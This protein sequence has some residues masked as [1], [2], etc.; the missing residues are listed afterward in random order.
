MST[1]ALEIKNLCKTYK[2]GFTA[3]KS[4]SLTVKPGD[5]LALLGP[6]GAGKSTLIGIVCSLVTK[7][8]GQFFVFGM[9]A[10]S[11]SEQVKKY[12]GVVPQEFNFN[13]F[14]PIIEIL[15]NQAGYY[16]IERKPAFARA[17]ILLRQLKLW[18]K[19]H[20]MA[21][22]LSGGMK[23]R[24]MIARAMMHEPKILIL[25]E[26]TAGVDVEIRRDMWVFLKQLNRQGTTI[27]LTTH[28]LEEA[29]QLCNHIAIIDAG[30]IIKDCS[31]KSLLKQIDRQC[32]ILDLAHPLEQVPQAAEFSF[33]QQDPLTLEVSINKQQS[34]NELFAWLSQQQIQVQAIRNKSNRLEQL[35][36]ELVNEG[37]RA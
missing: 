33:R 36:M 5:F 20:G 12:L 10:D 7:T 37:A 32:L 9:D 13:V 1:A 6:N 22:E 15:V 2:N 28:Y 24:L 19:R 21:R 3:L 35:F 26:P 23:R 11:H 34:I 30:C 29:E 18:D 27:I 16:G 14:E 31:M 4:A 17:E 25:D 8:S